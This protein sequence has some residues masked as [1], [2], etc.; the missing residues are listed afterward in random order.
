MRVILLSLFIS[1]FFFSLNARDTD[2]LIYDPNADAQ[3]QIQS[4]IEQ[5]SE[6]NKQVLIQVGGNWC[7][8]CIKLHDFFLDHEQIDSLIR[9]DYVLIR[10]NYSKDNKNPEVMEKLGFPQRFGFPVLVI[11][12]REGNL[13]HTQNTAYLEKDKSYSEEKIKE[14]LL[15]WNRKALDPETYV[16]SH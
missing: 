14:F 7:P 3:Q 15:D 4:A 12:D 5:A 8:W 2:T 16:S 9:A 6:E 13:I 10:V 11:L 1:G